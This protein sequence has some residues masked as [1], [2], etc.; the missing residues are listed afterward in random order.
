MQIEPWQIP[1]LVMAGIAGPTS[2]LW[3][4]TW[5]R[6]T[7]QVDPKPARS[8]MTPTKRERLR[9]TILAILT[10]TLLGIFFTAAGAETAN[11]FS[12]VAS[13]VSTLVSAVLTVQSYL[14]LQEVRKDRVGQVTGGETS[15]STS[16]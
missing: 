15:G 8:V 1:V 16:S 4:I 2:I 7:S 14:M 9:T 6:N 13:A 12:S 5:V 10:V 11:I 3:L